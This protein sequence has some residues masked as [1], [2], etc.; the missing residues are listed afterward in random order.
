MQLGRQ[1][2][3]VLAAAAATASA[4]P[5]PSAACMASPVADDTVFSFE[6][7]VVC[8]GGSHARRLAEVKR[9]AVL[10]LGRL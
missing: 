4:A 9:P 1:L 6:H 3:E 10:A 8:P 5:L 7:R 2:R